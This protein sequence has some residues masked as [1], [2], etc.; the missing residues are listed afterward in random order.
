MA[1][2]DGSSQSRAGT[3]ELEITEIRTG[4]GVG[5]RIPYLEGIL[6]ISRYTHCAE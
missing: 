6:W 5:G 3:Y 1:D 2:P 4:G